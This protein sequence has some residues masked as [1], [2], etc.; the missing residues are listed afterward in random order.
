MEV[1]ANGLSVLAG[2]IDETES[3]PWTA[4]IE[5][6]D[7]DG[8]ITGAVT[9]V[10]GAE[11]FVGTVVRGSTEQ[12]R[13]VA[14]IVGGAAG[15]ETMLPAK[16]Y[17]AVTAG[18]VIDDIMAESGEAFDAAG[19]DPSIASHQLPRW[20]RAR[21][22]A[23][24]ALQAIALEL[25]AVWR[26]S[27]AGQV[28]L[29]KAEA[30]TPIAGEWEE[31]DRDPSRSMV[32]IAPEDEPEA[33]PGTSVGGENVVTAR[34]VL[35]PSTLRQVL[36]IHDGTEKAQDEATIV[37]DLA[38]RATELTTIYGRWYA[39][40]V[41]A[42]EADGSLQ[43]LPDDELVRGNGLTK[44]PLLHGLPGC[45]VKVVP[46][47]LVKLFFENGNPKTPAC[48]L[49]P[50]GSSVL[51]VVLEAQTRVVIAGPIVLIGSDSAAQPI[52]LGNALKS[53]LETH[54]HPT[55]M[56]PSGPPVQA[57][58]LQTTLSVKH[59]LDG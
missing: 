3:G 22:E 32:V 27:R 47:Q 5:V 48:G 7:E 53:W 30:W 23:R 56:G 36:Q 55:A 13:Y 6:D 9:I 59:K 49:W 1:T 16:Y 19:S 46:G 58:T 45:T 52:P 34:T 38:R 37:A 50:D 35:T 18:T 25:G 14:E 15:L 31:V 4:R 8:A 39:A 20:M 12:G 28:V 33:R 29:V 17:F 2:Q 21:G 24:L 40:K 57:P 42:Q 43:I 11:S 10:A 41:I 44:V 26:V 51:E 54:T